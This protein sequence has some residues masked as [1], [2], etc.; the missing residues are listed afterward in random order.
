MAFQEEIAELY[1]QSS[2][3]RGDLSKL[4]AEHARSE[5]VLEE[6]VQAS[7][8]VVETLTKLVEKFGNE[9]ES[10]KFEIEQMKLQKTRDDEKMKQEQDRL[11]Q[12]VRTYYTICIP[13][14]W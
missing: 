8:N 7:R 2:V 13:Y 9:S 4:K 5:A 1:K 12:E 14:K 11:K 10:F 6:Q 3:A